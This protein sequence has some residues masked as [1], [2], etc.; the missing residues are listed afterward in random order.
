M[1][2]LFTSHSRAMLG[3]LV[4]KGIPGPVAEEFVND[5]FTAARRKWPQIRTGNPL[6]YTY[7]VANNLCAQYWAASAKAP[8]QEPW[9]DTEPADE[10]D[11]YS[12]ITDA[13]AVAEAMKSLSP[14]LQEVIELRYMK[15]LSV[16]ETAEKLGISEG[17]VKS[18]TSDALKQLRPRLRSGDT[19]AWE[20]ER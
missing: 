8:R 17:T 5:A 14:R 18:H 15:Q 6:A 11:E 13:L 16:R 19:E 3:S 1:I 12:A 7:K 4:R 9:P 10:R 2:E 20:E